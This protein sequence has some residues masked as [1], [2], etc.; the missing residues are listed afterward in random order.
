MRQS[1]CMK[2]TLMIKLV[3][4]E[5]FIYCKE[6]R[7][8][9][10]RSFYGSFSLGPFDAGQ[11]ITIANALRRTLLSELKGLAIT[12]AEI[13]GAF[14]E[15]STLPGVRDS[16]LD[17]LL[18]LK[19]I[20]LKSVNYGNKKKGT[21]SAATFK[22]KQIGYLKTRGPGIVTASELK[23]PPGIQCVDP[24]QYIATLSEEG[25]LNMKIHINEGKNYV[26]QSSNLDQNPLKKEAQEGGASKQVPSSLSF[27]QQN[28]IAVAKQLQAQGGLSKQGPGAASPNLFWANG[29]PNSPI[30][31]PIRHHMRRTLSNWNRLA[32]FFILRRTKAPRLA[33]QA[34]GAEGGEPSM[35]P[36]ALL[37][38]ASETKVQSRVQQNSPQRVPFEK[39][40]VQSIRTTQNESDY[41]VTL[42]FSSKDSSQTKPS[43]AQRGKNVE[44]RLHSKAPSTVFQPKLAAT[45]SRV[46]WDIGVLIPSDQ[47]WKEPL[48]IFKN[49]MRQSDSG[50]KITKGGCVENIK[51]R[52]LW[53]HKIKTPCLLNL[54]LRAS[55]RIK[56][57]PPYAMSVLASQKKE[58]GHSDLGKRKPST[59]LQ[60]VSV[61]KTNG[62]AEIDSKSRYVPLFTNKR[63]SAAPFYLKGSFPEGGLGASKAL[64]L[65][66]DA[67]FMPVNKVNYI[68]E[69]NEQSVMLTQVSNISSVPFLI[70]PWHMNLTATN[71]ATC[72]ASSAVINRNKSTISF[73]PFY[74]RGNRVEKQRRLP[75]LKKTQK[76]SVKNK[77]S[78]LLE[79]CLLRTQRFPFYFS[80]LCFFLPK[81]KQMVKKRAASSLLD[82]PLKGLIAR[83]KQGRPLRK[84]PT[85]LS[86]VF[87]E[88]QMGKGLGVLRSNCRGWPL[89]LLRKTPVRVKRSFLARSERNSGPLLNN[90]GDSKKNT[91]LNAKR[92]VG[93]FF[94]G[95]AAHNMMSVASFGREAI[96]SQLNKPSFSPLGLLRSLQRAPSSKKKQPPKKRGLLFASQSRQRL[97]LFGRQ[98]FRHSP[99]SPPWLLG[100]RPKRSNMR[101]KDHQTKT[102]LKNNIILEI[103]TN[104]SIH[105]RQALYESCKNLLSLFSKLEKAT[106]LAFPLNQC[107]YV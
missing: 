18:N 80:S 57:L 53:F 88:K 94:K 90:Q 56:K 77:Q 55:S 10:N 47:S 86:L 89:Q 48:I 22:N 44:N 16:I 85:L 3:K 101:L 20:V 32:P 6:T 33:A 41:G 14:H 46:N 65:T 5:F 102:A 69:T 92:T 27:L 100:C 83:V 17:I 103:W 95:A 43:F 39:N 61:A 9:S 106:P 87:F 21:S 84:T 96:S 51:T 54:L 72:E 68:I 7:I 71:S 73:S 50:F 19:D 49:F 91:R 98:T 40:A 11:S 23:L 36:L 25:I 66:I 31:T 75:L 62:R 12:S 24:D 34:K 64:P 1:K 52:R 70:P 59:I 2:N 107:D 45:V 28:P 104:G 37:G 97:M 15:Y 8:E 29:E 81:T 105:P 99:D 35:A 38:V 76:K 30:I 60:R 42:F 79:R 93:F 26:I 13:E 82:N 63:K 58:G 67:V 78:I 4:N 74:M